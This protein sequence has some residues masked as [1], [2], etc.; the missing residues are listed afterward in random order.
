MSPH[1]KLKH[2]GHQLWFGFRLTG[3][4]KRSVDSFIFR[5]RMGSFAQ[6]RIPQT[7]EA[8]KI[9]RDLGAGSAG[10]P[11]CPRRALP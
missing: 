1:D 6:K 11:A 3:Y 4:V 8:V 10:V 7:V 2:I 9:I 5:V